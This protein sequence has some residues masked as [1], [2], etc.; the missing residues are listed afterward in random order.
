MHSGYKLVSIAYIF[1]LLSK[2][3][4]L[5]DALECRV[6]LCKGR[7]RRARQ[8]RVLHR[9]R[10]LIDTAHFLKPHLV[11]SAVHERPVL[12]TT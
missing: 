1:M 10:L 7:L 11:H 5:A 2:P 9:T 12:H 6:C 8:Q 4:A 3:V